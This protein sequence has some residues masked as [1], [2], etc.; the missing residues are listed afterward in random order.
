[1]AFSREQLAVASDARLNGHNGRLARMGC[2]QLLF[3]GRDHF[4]RS[5]AMSG[6][7]SREVLNPDPQL[8]PK[9][10]ANTGNCNSDLGD[11]QLKN[12]RQRSLHF[13]W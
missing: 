7:Q 6:K 5:T 10:A 1:M 13:E 2:D 8:P 3:A 12:L 4:N 9:P 11:G